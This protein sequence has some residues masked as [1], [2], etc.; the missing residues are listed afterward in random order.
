MVMERG[1][2]REE[3]GEGERG[4]GGRE[5]EGGEG[6]RGKGRRRDPEKGDQRNN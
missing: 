4:R 6:E 3:G 5:R 1:R 2:G